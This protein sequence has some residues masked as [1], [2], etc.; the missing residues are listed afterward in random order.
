VHGEEQV[1]SQGGRGQVADLGRV[2][3]Q[4]EDGDERDRDAADLVADEGD[5]L[6]RPKAA[7][8]PALS[9]EDRNGESPSA[10]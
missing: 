9:K 7:E 8:L 1:G 5:D 6:P 2:R 4:R 3:V 10:R